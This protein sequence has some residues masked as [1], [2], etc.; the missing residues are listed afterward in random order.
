MFYEVLV[1]YFKF[2]WILYLNCILR[3]IILVNNCKF[4]DNI[5][6]FYIEVIICSKGSEGYF[7]ILKN[8]FIF[9]GINLNEEE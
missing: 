2:C 8:N 3:E 7:G 4:L 9:K 1:I 5:G 6:I